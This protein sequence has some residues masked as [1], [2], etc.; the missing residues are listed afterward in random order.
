LREP[1]STVVEKAVEALKE[2][3][4]LNLRALVRDLLNGVTLAMSRYMSAADLVQR[5]GLAF[6]FSARATR[7]IACSIRAVRAGDTA[8]PNAWAV[9]RS[10][11]AFDQIGQER[12]RSVKWR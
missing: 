10:E 5:K 2:Q 6:W 12:V 1:L 9:I 3:Q 8:A 11:P 7:M 4:L